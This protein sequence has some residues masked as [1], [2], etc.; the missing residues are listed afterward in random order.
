MSCGGERYVCQ[1]LFWPSSR[2]HRRRSRKALDK[3]IKLYI[4]ESRSMMGKA[5]IWKG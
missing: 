4:D 1:R 3:L 2:H 5:Q